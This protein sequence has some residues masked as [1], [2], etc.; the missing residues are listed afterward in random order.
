VL[1]PKEQLFVMGLKGQLTEAGHLLDN[2]LS[3]EPSEEARTQVGQLLLKVLDNYLLRA[4]RGAEEP[5]LHETG[6]LVGVACG[7]RN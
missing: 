5:F 4:R 6:D 2:W 1:N 3:R 7:R